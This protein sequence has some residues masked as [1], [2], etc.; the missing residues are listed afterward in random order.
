MTVLVSR[1]RRTAAP[2]RS[3]G[4]DFRRDFFNA[5]SVRF[6]PVKPFKCGNQVVDAPLLHL[7]PQ[8]CRQ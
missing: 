6:L 8:E 4:S 5:E 1:T 2:F 3:C 7:T